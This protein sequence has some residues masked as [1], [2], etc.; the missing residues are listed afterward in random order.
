MFVTLPLENE[1]LLAPVPKPGAYWPL[2]RGVVVTELYF[3]APELTVPP[4]ADPGLLTLN[5]PPCLKIF[6]TLISVSLALEEPEPEELEP[7]PGAD[8]EEDEFEADLLGLKLL[9]VSEAEPLPL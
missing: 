7:E 3:L 4:T 8:S 2:L 9:A 6:L 1:N 5:A